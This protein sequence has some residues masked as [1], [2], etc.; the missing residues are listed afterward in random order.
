MLALL[1]YAKIDQ[2]TDNYALNRALIEQMSLYRERQNHHQTQTYTMKIL[3]TAPR[4]PPKKKDLDGTK[5]SGNDVGE[6]SANPT[7]QTE[8]DKHPRKHINRS[9][10]LLTL[11][12]RLPLPLIPE[13]ASEGT[14]TLY[15]STAQ[16]LRQLYGDTSLF[17][18]HPHLEYRLLDSLQ[19]AFKI[20]QQNKNEGFQGKPELSEHLASLPMSSPELRKIWVQLLRGKQSS[21][22]GYPSLLEYMTVGDKQEKINVA[23]APQEILIAVF[24]DQALVSKLVAA[25]DHLLKVYIG[26]EGDEKVGQSQKEI[27]K[28]LAESVHDLVKEKGLV[29]SHYDGLLEYNI[30]YD[31]KCLT[32]QPD[33][34]H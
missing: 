15:E 19:E 21:E 16:L 24:E 13:N 33:R 11:R 7:A 22:D 10:E 6:S 12:A 3:E 34:N 5:V 4:S 29:E 27:N 25:R 1:T 2:F 23:F 14:P 17:R 26:S 9:K 20:Q 30:K 8:K 18:E 28:A 32:Q 31:K